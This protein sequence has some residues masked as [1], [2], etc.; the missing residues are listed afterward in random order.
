MTVLIDEIQ[1]NNKTIFINENVNKFS[2]SEI[3]LYK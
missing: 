1:N 3:H 2:L